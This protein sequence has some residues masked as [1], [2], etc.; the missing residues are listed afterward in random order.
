[1]TA[2]FPIRVT[3]RGIV[4][5]VAAGLGKDAAP[6]FR[7]AIRDAIR[8]AARHAP[9]SLVIDMAG[10][11]RLDAAALGVL[12]GARRRM[13]TWLTMGLCNVRR[14]PQLDLNRANV[15]AIIPVLPCTGEPEESL[16]QAS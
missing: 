10:V 5:R 15:P 4:V 16:P 11:D 3:E 1:M 2:Q 14:R 7:A 13:P 12:L 8:L 6:L 9:H